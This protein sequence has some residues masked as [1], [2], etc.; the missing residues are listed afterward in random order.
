MYLSWIL[1][2]LVVVLAFPLGMFVEKFTI[3]EIKQGKKYL[4]TIFLVSL[5][6]FILSVFFQQ[7][8]LSCS[9]AFFALFTKGSLFMSRKR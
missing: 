7:V 6:G 5:I 2:V 1:A 4:R 3:E 8:V 9:F